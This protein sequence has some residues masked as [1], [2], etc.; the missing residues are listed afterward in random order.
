MKKFSILIILLFVCFGSFA[1][2][3]RQGSGAFSQVIN[4]DG[5]LRPDGSGNVSS[6]KSNGGGGG[7]GGNI[8]KIKLDGILNSK[9]GLGYERVLNRKVTFGIDGL[10]QLPT[11]STSFS[12]DFGLSYDLLSDNLADQQG[13]ITNIFVPANYGFTGS[14]TSRF[15]VMPEVRYYFKEAP[16]GLYAGLYFKYRSLDYTNNLQYQ[17]DFITGPDTEWNFD[18]NFKMNTMT[19]GL[20]LGMQTFLLKRVSLD[21]VFFGIQYGSNIGSIE[22]LTKGDPLS[23][24]IQSDV[25]AGVNYINAN[26]PIV[27]NIFELRENTPDR[28]F[29]ESRFTSPSIRLP[30][31]RLGI[32]F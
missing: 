32:R 3:D 6:R 4:G 24:D 1:Q 11:K 13:G 7:I 12:E 17:D 18:F 10:Y 2:N 28:V 31:I 5:W 23:A 19:G 30:S 8:I 27:E 29:V 9:Y 16:R 25:Q 15:Y 21:L 20:A 26:L 14:E 22:M